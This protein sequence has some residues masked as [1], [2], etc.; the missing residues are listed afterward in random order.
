[1][2]FVLSGLPEVVVRSAASDLDPAFGSGGKV[3][4]DFFGL[5]DVITALALQPDGKILAAGVA[6]I[7]DDGGR[8]RSALARYNADGSL[9][10]T[11][12]QGGKI[13]DIPLPEGIAAMA[14]QNDGKIIV[15]GATFSG[16]SRYDFRLVR[17]NRDGG[18]DTSFAD[19]GSART[20]FLG[21]DDGIRAIVILPDG[22][23]VAAGFATTSNAPSMRGSDFALAK[24]TAN[25]LLDS[26]FGQGGK[27]TLD[28]LASRDEADALAL[29]A[30]GKLVAGGRAGFG[31][32]SGFGIARFNSNGT[33]DQSFGTNGKVITGNDEAQVFSLALQSDGKLIAGGTSFVSNERQEDFA[34]A[35]YNSDGSL[36]RSFGMGGQVNTDLANS[37][38]QGS[39]RAKAIALLPGGRVLAAGFTSK[40]GFAKFALVRYTSNGELDTAFGSGGKLI[41]DLYGFANGA[42]AMAIQRDGKIVV[43]GYA[44]TGEGFHAA[45]FALLRLIGDFPTFDLCT[46]DESNGNLLQVNTATGDYQFTNCAGLTV[47]GIGTLTRRGSLITLQ[48]NAADRRVRASIDTSTNRA[49]ASVQLL[50]SGRTFSITDRNITNNTCA[51]R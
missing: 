37:T 14:L 30:D 34:L 16:N 7:P 11:F 40:E 5:R 10:T 24:Y 50:S 44:G 1:M 38:L 25:G 27:A 4:T 39:D 6:Y 28:F 33:P 29:Q 26:S 17:L 35:R 41:I 51:C 43:A 23:I 15:G 2:A 49:T 22:R 3:V 9:D 48:H 13:T 12:G 18:L 47:G 21:R 19:Q 46:Q 36:D 42:T 31:D 32:G 20:D 45:D 8:S